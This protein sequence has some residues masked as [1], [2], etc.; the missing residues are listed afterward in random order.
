LRD[1]SAV[2]PLECSVKIGFFLRW[3]KHSL[4][5]AGNVLGDE[6]LA[7]SFCRSLSRQFSVDAQV[8]APNALPTEPVDV[9]VYLNDS[10]PQSA[11]A[12]R[13]VLY[14]QNAFDEDARKAVARLTRHS[15]DG[16][17]FFSRLLQDIFQETNPA[18]TLYLPFGVDLALFRPMTVEPRYQHEVSYVG[19]DIKGLERTWA[20]LYPAAKFDFGLYGNWAK[21]KKAK[22]LK[23]AL[24]QLLDREYRYRKLFHSI[25]RGKIPQE[26][27]PTLY[28]SSRINLNCSAQAC[29]DW[30]VITLRTYEVLACGGFLI[31]DEVPS[32]MKDL[33]HYVVFTR[34]GRHLTSQIRYYLKHDVERMEMAAKGQ[35][36]VKKYASIDVRARELL[37]YVKGVSA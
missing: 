20:Y 27:V 18:D 2:A 6:L 19:N 21:P 32:A 8:F 12:H 4:Q 36:Y 22:K 1:P 31:S 25:S 35:A 5:G 29:V 9:M 26:D 15:F 24:A 28:S 30:D 33:S 17:V 14:M 7:D 34:G 10:E 23:K 37:D 3:D 13:H 16:Y 11:Y